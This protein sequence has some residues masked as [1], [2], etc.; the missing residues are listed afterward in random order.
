MK[1]SEL[2]VGDFVT[3]EVFVRELISLGDRGYYYLDY[4]LNDGD[5][6]GQGI[7][8]PHSLAKWAKRSATADEIDRLDRSGARSNIVEREQAAMFRYVHTA[9]TWLL[10]QELLRRRS[11]RNEPATWRDDLTNE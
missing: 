5:P 8:S 11:R 2:H 10:E 9:P 1:A 4:S 3:N 6:I 7:C